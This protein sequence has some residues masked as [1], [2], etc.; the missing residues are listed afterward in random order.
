M[1]ALAPLLAQ[2]SVDLVAELPHAERTTHVSEPIG[3]EG[4]I[5]L[6]N[7]VP[8]PNHL[9]DGE[10]AIGFSCIDGH[11]LPFP[12]LQYRPPPLYVNGPLAQSF[13]RRPDLR[14]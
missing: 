3:G 4:Y 14:D 1:R 13:V 12:R 2:R 6:P 9:S 8:S 10:D 11:A 5:H 7:H